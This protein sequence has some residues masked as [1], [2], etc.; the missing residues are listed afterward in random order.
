[1]DFDKEK[2]DEMTLAL[3]YLVMHGKA[4]R[5]GP[6]RGSTG[7]PWTG[8]IQRDSSAIRKARRGR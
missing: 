4:G 2:V 8:C 7:R 1:M 6:G 3:L 5:S